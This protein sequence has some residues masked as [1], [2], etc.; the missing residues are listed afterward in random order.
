M[1]A[2]QRL[3][4]APVGGPFGMNHHDPGMM[5]ANIG[6]DRKSPFHAESRLIMQVGLI[7]IRLVNVFKDGQKSPQCRSF[8][9]FEK[10][11]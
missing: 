10:W 5:R 8:V 6:E 3:H 4:M 11:V 9:L 2:L 1:E 7:V